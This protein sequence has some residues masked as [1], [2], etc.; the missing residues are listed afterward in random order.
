[1]FSEEEIMLFI[2]KEWKGERKIK[3]KNN[4]YIVD[5]KQ[6]GDW[7]GDHCFASSTYNILFL[8]RFL[9]LVVFFSLSI[10]LQVQ[11][12]DFNRHRFDCIYIFLFDAGE[13]GRTF[14]WYREIETTK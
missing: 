13:M 3:N 1:M 11:N 12:M 8:G 6:W 14:K 5:F 9:I 7:H 10:S 4:I 2:S